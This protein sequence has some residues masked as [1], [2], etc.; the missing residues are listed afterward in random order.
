MK[1]KSH[2]TWISIPLGLI[3]GLLIALTVT[4]ATAQ[5]PVSGATTFTYQG[6]LTLDG[7]PISGACDLAFRL[8]D[9]AAG[10]SQV[11]QPISTTAA[12]ADGFFTAGLDFGLAA[13][14]GGQA[15]WLEV[16][17]QC[18]GDTA[19]A[20]LPRQALTADPYAFDAQVAPWSGLTG[21]PAGW[22]DNVDNDTLYAAGE[23]LKLQGTTF[24]V[25]PRTYQQRVTGVCAP[26]YAFR[27]IRE[28]GS[29]ACEQ[30][31]NGDITA[32]SPGTGLLGGGASGDVTLSADTTYLQRIVTGTCP[33]N[34]SIQ[35]I[36]QGGTVTCH[37]DQDTLYSA[38]NQL[39]LVDHT[40]TLHDGHTFGLD[41][42]TL[43]GP[44]QHGSFFQDASN[45]VTG[46]L[47]PAYFSARADLVAE[48]YLGN[49]AGDIAQNNG[50]LQPN[51]NADLL[52]T[53]HGDYYRN[54]SHINAGLL[55][56][57]FFSAYGDLSN[58]SRLGGEGGIALN[59]GNLQP[60]LN[61]DRLDSQHATAYQQRVTGTCG[62]GQAINQVNVDGTVGCSNV[63]GGTITAVN[64]GT[65]LSGGGDSLTVTLEVG[66][67]YRLPQGCGASKVPKWNADTLVWDCATDNNSGGTLTSITGVSGIIGSGSTGTV[68]L[69]ADL[70][71]LQK[72]VTDSS[73][74]AGSSISKVNKDG[75]VVCETDDN[76]T[77]SA[78]DGVSLSGT[79]FSADSAKIQ[80]KVTTDCSADGNKAM[81]KISS[82]GTAECVAVNSTDVDV[83]SVTASTG[84]TGGGTSGAVT[85]SVNFTVH[86]NYAS[87]TCNDGGNP[88]AVL[89]HSSTNTFCFLNQ[90]HLR[91]VDDFDR[92]ENNK[93]GW[94][95]CKVY[96]SSN[97]WY[98][99]AWCD[100]DED[101]ESYVY[102]VA[103]CFEW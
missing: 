93:K 35:A 62:T 51:L 98:I 3:L 38:G 12:V 90:I 78:G 49:Q 2:N 61:A 82:D 83:Q 95:G 15:R 63:G 18:S 77:Y 22:A 86:S 75:T 101:G 43:G 89:V 20:T 27:E 1:T 40:F 60:D 50:I 97:S 5:A 13:F 30:T 48:G 99:D 44:A 94:A 79:T 25:D 14:S 19:F 91:D 16:A 84:L 102:C 64:A 80:R 10:G 45:I 24:S 8:Y 37:Q 57:L 81:S 17:V 96:E 100:C 9:Q 7:Q 74:N 46:T 53:Q 69:S 21:V 71:F 42:D 68:T 39:E 47:N 55:G 103:S 23:G 54:A 66:S 58:E 59:D 88:A 32:V 36:S 29:V 52:D 70:D 76:T 56:Y 4:G 87:V 31:W 28:D 34:F 65:G 26:G 6:R 41:A 92:P 72:N 33:A 73:C 11:G 85:L 67:T